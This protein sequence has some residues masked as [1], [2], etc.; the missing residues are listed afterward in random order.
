MKSFAGSCH[1]GAIGFTFET[2]LPPE[3]WQIRECQCAFCRGH[4][5]RTTSDPAGRVSFHIRDQSLLRRYQFGLRTADFLIC[6][7]CGVYLSVVLTSP[8]GRFATLNVNALRE[9]FEFG[10]AI[11]V[12]YDGES[13]DARRRRRE[14]RWTSVI[15]MV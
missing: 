6:A 1:C 9:R 3:Q 12:S 10:E 13:S 14:E 8:G 2:A 4:G 7:N 5:A 11:P 15:G